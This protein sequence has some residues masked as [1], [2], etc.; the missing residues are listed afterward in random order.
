MRKIF[1]FTLVVCS[2]FAVSSCKSSKNNAY[3]AAYEQAR[4]A[5]GQGQQSDAIEIAPVAS[6]TV[7]DVAEDTTYRTEKVVLASGNEGSL[8]AFSVVCGSFSTKENAEKVRAA[9]LNEGY[10]AIVVQN[11]E[12]GMYRVV[13]ASFDTKEE[14]AASRA[15]FKAA[16]PNNSDYQKA[17][18]LYNK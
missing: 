5:E 10:S 6:S 3:E 1:V 11:P 18:L 15:R 16:H 17:W 7:K 12:S 4:L 14:A 9:L 8:K 2:V 13:C